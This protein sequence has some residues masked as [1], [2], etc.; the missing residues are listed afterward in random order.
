[1]WGFPW[2]VAVFV[3]ASAAIVVN[4]LI[5]EPIDSAIGLA[6]VGIGVPVYLLAGRAP[7]RQP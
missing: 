2:T 7:P 6:L 5:S 3:V 4:R 1:V